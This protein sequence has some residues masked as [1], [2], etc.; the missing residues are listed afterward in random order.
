M[1]RSFS[2]VFGRRPPCGAQLGL[3][4]RCGNQL[5]C[6]A[7]LLRYRTERFWGNISDHR[8]DHSKFPCSL[9]LL[10]VILADSKELFQDG[11][12]RPKV[13]PSSCLSQALGFSAF[14]LKA[15][16]MLISGDLT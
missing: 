4:C 5:N 12:T 8:D 9:W 6:K 7:K 3:L 13:W 16:R 2:F 10:K 15:L 14:Q 1:R 11:S